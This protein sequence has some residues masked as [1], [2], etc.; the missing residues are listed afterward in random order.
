VPVTLDSPS[1]VF[2]QHR[3][4]KV[5]RYLVCSARV[6]TITDRC[7]LRLEECET[8]LAPSGAGGVADV[9]ADIAGKT[10]TCRV[11]GHNSPRTV[12]DS[13]AAASATVCYQRYDKKFAL[14]NCHC[15][16]AGRTETVLNGNGMKR[17]GNQL[18]DVWTQKVKKQSCSGGD[19]SL[20]L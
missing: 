20:K 18:W 14:E 17:M 6:R 11:I 7:I 9:T 5:E 3:C 12:C 13:A 8:C 15:N 16:L 19:K 1:A 2:R 4:L 10:T